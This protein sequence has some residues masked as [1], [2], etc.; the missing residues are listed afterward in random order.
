V[1]AQVG[2]FD[3]LVYWLAMAGPLVVDPPRANP[4]TRSGQKMA[5]KSGSSRLFERP[6]QDGKRNAMDD[7]N[8]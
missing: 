4:D 2:H 1:S 5:S 7:C 3:S 8:G 6:R